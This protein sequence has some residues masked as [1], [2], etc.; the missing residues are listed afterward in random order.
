MSI[1]RE[2][3]NFRVSI[4]FSKKTS[5]SMELKAFLFSRKKKLIESVIVKNDEAVFKTKVKKTSDVILL[6]VPNKKGVERVTDYRVLVS[7]Y[8]AYKPIIKLN[9]K[10][11][12]EILPIPEK[13]LPLW[14]I[15]K[16]RVVG[17]VSK[18][19]N[20]NN[21]IE[22]RGLCNMR[23]HI[24]EVDKIHWLIPRIPDD[25]FIKIP[26]LVFNPEIPIPVPSLPDPPIPPLPD[27]Q[28]FRN[29]RD[30][31]NIFS[32]TSFLRP[33]LNMSSVDRE[34]GLSN[35]IQPILTNDNIVRTLKS[36]NPGLIKN[37][38]INK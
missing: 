18:S 38:I 16:C 26:D 17:N 20:I 35:I 8:K 22:R 5:E 3:G 11:K 33:D 1:K 15:R 25:I 4:K 9:D 31:D 14:F 23:I 2:D 29:F 12:F 7:K 36:K 24:C 10:R 13:F 32:A 19:F 37:M 28:R 30:I 6:V 21:F 34:I 27:P